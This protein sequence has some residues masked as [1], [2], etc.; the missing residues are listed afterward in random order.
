[1]RNLF[2]FSDRFL[3]VCVCVYVYQAHSDIILMR[4]MMEMFHKWWR[5]PVGDREFPRVLEKLHEWWRSSTGDAEVPR[6]TIWSTI[7]NSPSFMKHERR[8][9]CQ[10]HHTPCPVLA[11]WTRCQKGFILMFYYW[12]LGIFLWKSRNFVNP[13]PSWIIINIMPI[14]FYLCPHLLFHR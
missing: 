12:N 13:H 6:R 11:L 3:Y 1:M 10:S 8:G 7:L 4:K 9:I 14:S 2:F 5:S